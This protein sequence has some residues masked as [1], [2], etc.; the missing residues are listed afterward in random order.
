VRGRVAMTTSERDPGEQT[1]STTKDLSSIAE[2]DVTVGRPSFFTQQ[3]CIFVLSHSASTSPGS[4][5]ERESCCKN[6]TVAQ[7]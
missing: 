3:T 4:Q 2:L 7:E 1:R 5:H 6:K